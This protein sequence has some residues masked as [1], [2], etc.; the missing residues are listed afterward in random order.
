MLNLEQESDLIEI[1]AKLSAMKEFLTSS[2]GDDLLI[3]YKRANNILANT[4]LVGQLN[5]SLFVV[6]HEVALFNCITDYAQKI[7][8]ELSLKHYSASLT[9]LAKMRQPIADFFDNVM[10][11]DQDAAVANNRLLLLAKTKQI[12]D[13]IAKF[14]RL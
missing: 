1:S 9:L 8:L 2:D 6:D 4:K 5:E 3:A 7:E 11:K 10:V 13:K 12:F 14:D